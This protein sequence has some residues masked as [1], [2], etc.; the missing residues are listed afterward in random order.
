MLRHDRAAIARCRTVARRPA[1]MTRC[2]SRIAGTG[3]YLPAKVLTNDDLDAAR[4]H[5]R[6]MDP[7]AHRHPPA[8]HRGRRRDD[9][10]TSRSSRAREALEA[11]GLAPA[12]IDLI[13]VATTTPDMIFPRP[14]ASCR[15]SSASQRR[16]RVRRAGGVRGFVYALAIADQ[17][18]AV[19]QLPQRA[20][21]R[22]RDLFAHPR[23]ERPRHVRAVR[24]R[25]RRGRAARR[26]RARH[27]GVAPACRRPLRGHPVACPGSVRDGAVSGT[28]FLHD[29]R[30]C[31]VQVRGEGARRSRATRR[32]PR[33][34]CQR[35]RSTG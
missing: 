11:A 16:R 23:L 4:R 35:A 29:G 5:Q 13:I 8:P 21:R 15:R 1:R 34:T 18:R 10:A 17:Y 27:P 2:T 22:R 20:G 6:R 32:S 28:P 19:G 26:R 9:V 14:R 12:D 7:H 33:P 25:R 31:G 30:Q 3:S 24:R